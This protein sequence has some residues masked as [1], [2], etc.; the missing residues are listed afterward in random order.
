M[1]VDP[2]FLHSSFRS[3]HGG[4]EATKQSLRKSTKRRE[5]IY[6]LL[7]YCDHIVSHERNNIA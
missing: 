7:T 4:K 2:V 6:L 1:D 5:Q 3:L